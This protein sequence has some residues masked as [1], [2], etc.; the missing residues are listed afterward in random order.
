MSINQS[1][2][3]PGRMIQDNLLVSQELLKGYNRKNGPKRCA[4]KIDIAQAYDTVNWGFLKQ[5][6]IHFGFHSKMIGCVMTCVTGASFSIYING[7]RHWYFKNGRGLR[8][9]DLMSPYLFTGSANFN[10]SEES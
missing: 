3:V 9:G 10:C 6:P 1:A 7:E 4:L 2:F 5:I 8:Q